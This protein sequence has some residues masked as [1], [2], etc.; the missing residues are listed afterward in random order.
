MRFSLKTSF[1][2]FVLSSALAG[3]AAPAFADSY[4]QGIDPHNPP[5]T[6]NNTRVLMPRSTT[7][8]NV[9]VMP[10]GSIDGQ[11]VTP[12]GGTTYRERYESGEGQYYRG[13]FPPTP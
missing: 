1:A 10:T 6:Q 12:I 9:D 5:G 2:A 4:Y 7:P 13:I 3:V 8:S 11:R